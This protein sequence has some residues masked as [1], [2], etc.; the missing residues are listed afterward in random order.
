MVRL[1]PAWCRDSCTFCGACA[2]VCPVKAVAV[3]RGK[4]EIDS[5]ICV[6]CL[7]C[8]EMCPTGAMAVAPNFLARMLMP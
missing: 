7:C 8:H 4:I 3:A 6:R 2:A 5:R 1:K